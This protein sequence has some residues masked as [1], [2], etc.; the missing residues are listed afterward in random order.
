MK[1]KNFFLNH[2]TVWIVVLA[3]AHI[4]PVEAQVPW[5]VDQLMSPSELSDVINS[6]SSR[7][8]MVF[9]IG[10]MALIK[11]SIDIGPVSQKTNLE[12]FRNELSKLPKNTDIVIYCGCCPFEN[13]PNIRPAFQLL[14]DMGFTNH[15]LLNLRTNI[16]V[17]WM[18]KGYPVQ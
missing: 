17:D 6:S 18:N 5:K 2:I 13:C 3:S 14:N 16:K 7:K 4:L 11:G 15:K 9:S 8:P 10:V 12:K 1:K